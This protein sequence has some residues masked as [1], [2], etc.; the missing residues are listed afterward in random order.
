MCDSQARV[1]PTDQPEPAQHKELAA[2]NGLLAY[3]QAH[4]KKLGEQAAKAASVSEE[5]YARG[6]RAEAGFAQ[7]S[8]KD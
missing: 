3:E 8:M 5:A 1:D 4:S 7:S 6:F 2:N